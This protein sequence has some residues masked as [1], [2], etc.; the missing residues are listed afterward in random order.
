M[1]I[2]IKLLAGF[3]VVVSLAVIQGY[4]AVEKMDTTNRLV[5]QMYDGPLMTI[6]F[7]RSAKTNFLALERSVQRGFRNPELLSDEDYLDTLTELQETIV[8]DLDVVLERTSDQR[9]VDLIGQINAEQEQWWDLASAAIESAGDGAATLAGNARADEL[10]AAVDGD[11]DLVV[12]YA[13]EGGYLFRTSSDATI[14]ETRTF[15]I[16]M[17]A[18]TV[19]LGLLIASLTAFSICRPMGRMTQ[20]MKRLSEGDLELDVPYTSRRDEIGAMAHAVQIF[21]DNS[22]ERARLEAIQAE[23]AQA[24]EAA[25]AAAERKHQET[26]ALINDFDLS[27]RSVLDGLD[28]A[29]GVLRQDA[30]VLTDAAD[31]GSRRSGQVTESAN[32]TNQQ[33]QA[34]AAAAEELSASIAE[35]G[36]MVS[37]SSSISGDAVGEA[38]Q[39]AENV[40]ALQEASEKIREVVTLINEIAEQTN[41]LALNATIEA[42][43]AGDAGKGFAV[44][45]SEVKAL[46]N[47]TAAATEEI[48]SQVALMQSATERTTTSTN[49]IGK[50]IER[51][52]EIAGV[53]NQT[54][55]QQNQATLEITTVVQQAAVSANEIC[56]GMTEMADAARDT[57]AVSG[58]V[59]SAAENLTRQA[60]VMREEV[61]QFLTMVQAG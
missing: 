13:A 26:G 45:A 51:I 43:R 16:A 55:D 29:A 44:V 46:A 3:L 27:V 36:R 40:Q 11:L 30:D 60:A 57:E 10:A 12:E 25:Q 4:I 32:N 37:E 17:I 1:S 47:Q 48:A 9:I 20:S 56:Q 38:K 14:A 42:A 49:D 61:Q 22:V 24:K 6:N 2:K 35:I 28:Q 33:S 15:L 18:G 53:I 21:K 5:G 41:L 39:A 19:L 50:T 54:V 59:R 34:V 8:E 58:Q 31:R 23:E 7:A 52:A